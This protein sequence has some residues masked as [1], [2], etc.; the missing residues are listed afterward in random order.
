MLVIHV[1]L[2]IAFSIYV[3]N[4]SFGTIFNCWRAIANERYGRT[5][6][7]HDEGVL[8]VSAPNLTYTSFMVITSYIHVLL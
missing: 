6:W 5:I 8:Q 7:T 2:P 1:T 3:N 4:F